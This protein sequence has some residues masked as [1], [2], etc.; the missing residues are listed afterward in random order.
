M[1]YPRLAPPLKGSPP[2]LPQSIPKEI[3]VHILHGFSASTL[4][5]FGDRL[6]YAGSCPLHCKVLSSIPGL[7]PQDANTTPLPPQ[8]VTTKMSPDIAKRPLW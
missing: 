6:F 3:M 4:L 7:Y 2:R 1:L 5:P 8:A